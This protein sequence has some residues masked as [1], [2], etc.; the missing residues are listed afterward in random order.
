LQKEISIDG[1]LIEG[2][3]NILNAFNEHFVNVSKIVNKTKYLPE[4]FD[5]LNTF[6]DEKLR[7]IVFNV[8]LWK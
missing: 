3:S 5:K 4:K 1:K 7:C 2:S 8:E 6:L